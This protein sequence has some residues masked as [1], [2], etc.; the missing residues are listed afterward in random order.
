MRTYR[1]LKALL[2]LLAAMLL[3][4]IVDHSVAWSRAHD[5]CE[6]IQPGMGG[7]EVNEM[8]AGL[9][10]RP[11]LVRVRGDPARMLA[12][13]PALTRRQEFVQFA[14]VFRGFLFR[15]RQCVVSVKGGKVENS[16]VAD[17]DAYVI[18][19]PVQTVRAQGAGTR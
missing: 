9:P 1:M 8:L 3:I 7:G 14:V 13:P 16:R 19:N 15:T 12:T 11:G 17:T 10:E 4:A 18:L 2:S 5:V 6:A